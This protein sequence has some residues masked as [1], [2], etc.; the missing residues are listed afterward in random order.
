MF[1][2]LFIWPENALGFI[3]NL[4]AAEIWKKVL[5]IQQITVFGHTL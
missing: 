1:A 4:E 2:V 5:E 3:V